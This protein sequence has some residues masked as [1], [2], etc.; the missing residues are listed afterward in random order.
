M[1]RQPLIVMLASAG[2]AVMAG[3]A[4][5]HLI[6]P[7]HDEFSWWLVDP[8]A[9]VLLLIMGG[10]YWRGSRQ[11]SQRRSA[12]PASRRLRRYC[13]WGGWLTLAIALASP[14]DPL[15]EELFTAHMVQHELLM[16]VAAP[17]LVLA[18]PSGPLLR[19]LQRAGAKAVGVVLRGR[20]LRP[21]WQWLATPLVAWLAHAVVLW[22]WHLPVLFS[23]SLESTWVHALQHLSFLW[24]ALLFWW[25]LVRASRGGSATGVIYLFTT[26]I[27]SCALGALLTFAPT[28][29]Y[30]PYLETT[31]AWGLTPLAD[32]QL[33]GLIMW[34]PA[35]LVFIAAG[36]FD[37]ARLLDGVNGERTHTRVID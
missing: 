26:A 2:A 3:P 13:F 33:G 22:G 29:W 37:V 27:H 8:V 35:G 12:A 30:P 14:L 6:G 10:A 9:V 23:A 15:G 5:A 7:A 18:R 20:L 31:A 16:L 34:V 24:V 32:Q 19:G 4:H 21:L 28:P 36:L 17:L 11:M 1:L 25:A